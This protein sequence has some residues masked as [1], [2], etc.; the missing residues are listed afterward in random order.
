MPCEPGPLKTRVALVADL[1]C[2]AGGSS[3][4]ARRALAS[5]GLQ[6]NLVAVNHWNVAIE[7]HSRNHPEARH[8]CQDVNGVKPA[9]IVPEGRLD[10]LMAS[11]TCTYHSRARGG[12]PINDQGPHGS[13][14]DRALV[15]RIAGQ[16]AARRERAGIRRLGPARFADRNTDQTPGRRIF[17]GLDS[18]APRRRVQARQAHPQCRGFRR[19]DDA[20]TV[21]FDG[22]LRRQAGPL[23]RPDP[24]PIG[25]GGPAGPRRP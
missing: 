10:L 17:P 14:G 6:M 9:E 20:R 2:G 22:A 1:F 5:L 23:A 21:L 15:H 8:Y 24:Q 13:L 4:G 11:P 12:K 18:G 7:T 16:R 19:G 3:T 25:R